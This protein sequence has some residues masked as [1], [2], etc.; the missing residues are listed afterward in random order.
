MPL[1]FHLYPG[2]IPDNSPTFQRWV[3]VLKGAQVPEGRPKRRGDSA[4]PSGLPLPLA[5]VPNVE[6]L[7]YCRMS[8]RDKHLRPLSR[9]SGKIRVRSSGLPA[10]LNATRSPVHDSAGKPDALQTLRAPTSPIGSNFGHFRKYAED[11]L[12]RSHNKSS[13]DEKIS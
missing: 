10:L 6:T 5:V 13:R 8:L 9:D 3:G 4:V 1:R 12:S 11:C 2:G 7:G